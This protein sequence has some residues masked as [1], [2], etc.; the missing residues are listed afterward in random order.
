MPLIDVHTHMVPDA[1]IELV[2]EKGRPEYRI[3]TGPNGSPAVMDGDLMELIT[4]PRMYDYAARIK[5]MDAQG[6]D[7]SIV[8]LTAPSV[9]WGTAETSNAAAQASND[10]MAAAQAAYPDRIRYLATLPWQHPALAVAELERACNNGAVGVM[11]LAN[12]RGMELNDPHVAPIWEAIDARALPVLLHP[13]SAPGYREMNLGALKGSV[14]FTFDTSL[15]IGK[16]A[17][18][19]FFDRYKKL[20]L[21]ASHAGGTL[22]FIYGR[23]DLFAETVPDKERKFTRAPSEYFR[24]IYYDGITCRRRGGI[25]W[26]HSNSSS[27]LPAP[28]ACFSAPTIST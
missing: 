2:R 18:D 11:V 27:G 26:M 6:M 5:M 15:S 19:D 24:E 4:N 7:I 13:C 14:G 17:L 10:D 21:I 28:T 20:K 22:P 16:L 12:I 23:I 8:S 9:Y 3:E 1:F 25:S